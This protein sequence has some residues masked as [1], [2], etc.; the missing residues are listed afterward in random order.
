MGN[1]LAGPGTA[2]E[3][4]ALDQRVTGQRIAEQ[5]ALA[6]QHTEQA[7]GQ[8]GVFADARQLQGHQRSDFRRFDDHRIAGSQGRGD[9]LRFAGNR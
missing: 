3:R 5:R 4:H 7:F 2:G 1:V 6:R 9:F 8:P